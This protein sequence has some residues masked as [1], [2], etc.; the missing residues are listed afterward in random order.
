M[1]QATKKQTVKRSEQLTMSKNVAWHRYMFLY[2]SI[3]SVIL[4]TSVLGP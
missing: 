3:G 1:E 2:T 4:D